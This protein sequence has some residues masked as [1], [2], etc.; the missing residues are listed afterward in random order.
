[1][2]WREVRWLKTLLVAL[3][4]SSFV[5]VF[6]TIIGFLNWLDYP[7]THPGFAGYSWENC[8][9][10]AAFGGACIGVLVFVV[11]FVIG[12]FVFRKHET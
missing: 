3:L 11:C 8:L 2:N 7:R 12:L 1:M 4:L 9:L 6:F 10:F 5:S